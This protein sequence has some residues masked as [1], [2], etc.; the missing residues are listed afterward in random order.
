[1]DGIIKI[2][3]CLFV[4]SPTA[5]TGLSLNLTTVNVGQSVEDMRQRMTKIFSPKSSS[6]S[7]MSNIFRK[8]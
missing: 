4:R 3:F 1:M 6:S 5:S 8:K 2:Y 7:S